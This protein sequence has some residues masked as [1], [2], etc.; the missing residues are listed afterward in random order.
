MDYFSIGRSNDIE[1][2]GY[3]PQTSRISRTGFH[4]DAFNS[5]R[6]VKPDE[7]PAF[8]PNFALDIHP[9][10]I[11]TDVLDS[12]VLDFGI[13][14]SEKLRSI[15][16]EYNLPPHRFYP[17]KVF[18]SSK[19]YYWL[20]FISKS[21][22]FIDYGK[23]EIE[24]YINRPPFKTD[25]IKLFNSQRE[26]LEAKKALPYNK[27]M[28]YK[29]IFLRRNF[30]EYDLFEISGAQYF[31]MISKTLKERFDIEKI[32]GL[33]YLEYNKIQKYL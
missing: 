20:H 17:I 29:N 11:E 15:L 2:I 24:I 27:A 31:T 4:I 18:N 1:I 23:T 19:Y 16:K 30:S 13:I 5:E 28:K 33:E 25:S 21:E 32:T 26:L 14:I 9:N 12:A 22:D 6:Q 8:E 3:Y 7:F 10:A